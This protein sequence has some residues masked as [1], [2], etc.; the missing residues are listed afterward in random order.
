MST[1][2]F[3]VV[4]TSSLLLLSNR[5]LC[6]SC[7]NAFISFSMSPNSVAFICSIIYQFPRTILKPRAKSASLAASSSVDRR[8]M[9]ADPMRLDEAMLIESTC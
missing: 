4:M 8:D 7:F 2:A 1:S 5:I 3:N 9:D 6:R